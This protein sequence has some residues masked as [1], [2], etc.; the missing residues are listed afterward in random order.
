MRML[1]LVAFRWT[2]CGQSPVAADAKVAPLTGCAEGGSQHRA[3]STATRPRGMI[4]TAGTPRNEW[5]GNRVSGNSRI[6]ADREHF[7]DP[8]VGDRAGGRTQAT[9]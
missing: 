5:W 4:T 6:R 2:G 7:Q 8:W 9:H 3:R 1:A